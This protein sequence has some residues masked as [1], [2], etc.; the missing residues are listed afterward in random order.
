MKSIGFRIDWVVNKIKLRRL[1]MKW[2]FWNLRWEVWRRKLNDKRYVWNIF[3]IL[4]YQ[5]ISMSN[6][7][8]ELEHLLRGLAVVLVYWGV[9][10]S[11]WVVGWIQGTCWGHWHRKSI[12]AGSIIIWTSHTID[13]ALFCVDLLNGPQVSSW[14]ISMATCSQAGNW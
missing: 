11:A 9:L 3:I 6:W 14:L 5:C 2:L 10:D 8:Q 1:V 12:I 7:S 13:L 4:L